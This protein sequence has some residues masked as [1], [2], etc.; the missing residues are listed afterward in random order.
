M[1]ISEKDILKA[2]DTDT[3]GEGS[4]FVPTALSAQIFK[5][6]RDSAKLLAELPSP[7]TMPTNPYK[8]PVESGDPTVY[9]V[10]QSTTDGG[11]TIGASDPGTA[12]ITL[13]AK[14]LACRVLFSTELDE[15]SIVNIR[16]YIM[17]KMS[18]RISERIDA[19]LLNGDTTSGTGNI[20][21]YGGTPTSTAGSADYYLAANG[22]IKNALDNSVTS[23]LSTLSAANILTLIGKMGKYAVDPTKVVLVVDVYTYY[24][25][26]GLT[27]V[28]TYDQFGQY[29]TITNGVL[30]NL[31]GSKVIVSSELLKADT[32]G[33]VN[34]TGGSNTKGRIV[35][36]YTPGVLTGFRRQ[37]KIKTDENIDTDQIKLVA[38]VRFAQVFPLAY[39]AN[40]YSVS[41]L[42]YNIT[43]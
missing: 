3:S 13:T 43:V 24:K 22:L 14:K 8:Y 36:V 29:A 15:D 32:A 34:N 25:L 38:T 10:T 6:V 30:T 28:L 26:M 27:Q 16:E 19:L 40:T 31:F 1:K 33:R 23:D 39:S 42:G 20:N 37:I 7:V 35:A 4:E 18:T 12:D 41:A 21:K 17:T 11:T 2:L 5:K 9:Y